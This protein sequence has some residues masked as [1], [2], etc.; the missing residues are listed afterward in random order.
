MFQKNDLFGKIRLL[1]KFMSP[2][3]GKQTIVIHI[4]SNISRSK[5]NQSIKCGQLI[6][7]NMTNI[8]LENSNTKY[9]GETIPRSF[10]KSQ[11]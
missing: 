11:K 3:P 8:F 9:G 2:Q 6:E 10:N 7:Y 4:L 5:G 1:S